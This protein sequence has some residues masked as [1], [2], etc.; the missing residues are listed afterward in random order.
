MVV[1]SPS[2]HASLMDALAVSEFL[3]AFGVLCEAAVLRL[4]DIQK[5]AARPLSSPTL[6]KLY[7]SLL[8]CV[9]LEKVHSAPASLTNENRAP[10]KGHT[11]V[12]GVQLAGIYI[13]CMF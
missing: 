8:R 3:A 6:S 13:A 12:S 9:L 10:R 7:M 1:S 4:P 2:A 5:A 11:L